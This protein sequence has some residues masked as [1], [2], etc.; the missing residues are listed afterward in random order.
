MYCQLPKDPAADKKEV[1]CEEL[2]QIYET[3]LSEVIRQ[4]DAL[5]EAE[6]RLEKQI[7]LMKDRRDQWEPNRG[8][9]L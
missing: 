8:G 2:M 3:N 6:L 7:E 4:R 5:A 9:E 1:Y